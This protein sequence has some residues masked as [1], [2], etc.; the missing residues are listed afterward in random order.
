M[1]LA[2]LGAIAAIQQQLPK[3]FVVSH[4]GVLIIGIGSAMFHATLLYACQILDELPMILVSSLL[5]WIV[6]DTRPL[7]QPPNLVIP[8]LL[9]A[10]DVFFT[11]AYLS[12]PK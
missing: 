5:A 1:A 10:F 2:L 8:S 11:Y 6:F 7:A 12:F 3:R 9:F 4:T